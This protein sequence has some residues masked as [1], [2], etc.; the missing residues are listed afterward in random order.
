MLDRIRQEP[1]LVLGA[2]Q[3]LVA[4]AVGFGLPVT[5]EQ[6]GLIVAATG[7]VLSV[8]TRTQVTPTGTWTATRPPEG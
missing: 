1:A 7:A 6:V 4:M 8:V 3:A 5:A 2:V